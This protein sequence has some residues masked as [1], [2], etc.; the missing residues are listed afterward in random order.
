MR[1]HKKVG[2]YTYG[3]ALNKADSEIIATLLSNRGFEISFNEN[4]DKDIIIVNTCTVKTPTERKII[5]KLRKL[6]DLKGKTK[7]IVTGC[8]PVAQ[9]D[10]VNEFK[11]FSFIGTN[12]F[13]ILDAIEYI[14]NPKDKKKR[15]VKISNERNKSIE[16]ER[17]F[18]FNPFVEIIPIAQGCL[19]NCSYCITKNARGSLRSLPEEKIIK[20]MKKV[21]KSNKVKEIWLTAQDTGAYGLDLGTTLPELLNKISEEVKGEFF[22]RVGMMNPTHVKKF[23][24]EL[25]KSYKENENLY[26]FLHLPLQSGD[27]KILNDMKRGYKVK[28]FKEI[29]KKFRK[30]IPRI[31]IST[32]VIVGFP[33]ETEKEFLNTLKLIKEIKP[34]IVN[35]SRFW[36]R[37]GTIASKMKELPGRETKRRSRIIVKLF[38]EIGLRRNKKW[39]SWQGKV[40]V[41][42][43]GKFQNSYVAR[44][45]AYKPIIINSKENLLGKFV[46]V[47][48]KDATYFDLRGEMIKN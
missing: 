37:P 40:L 20:E 39:I 34:D 13:D 19:G 31:T 11:N 22:I 44:N 36:S 17:K 16:L 5:R 48:I 29:I 46:K 41:S 2:I 4:E 7:V 21:I 26:K 42:E 43:L 3:C 47:K 1:K 24:N 25:V 23:L 8:M 9:P 30:E 35:I 12:V 45:F 6:E 15:F 27:D 10:I 38:K 33:T 18:R 14:L 32:D 28:D